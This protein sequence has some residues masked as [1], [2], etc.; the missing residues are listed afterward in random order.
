MNKFCEAD[1]HVWFEHNP[2]EFDNF[3]AH[4]VRCNARKVNN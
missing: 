1:G 2:T 4:C 3:V